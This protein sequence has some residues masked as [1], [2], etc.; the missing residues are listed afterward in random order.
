[1]WITLLLLTGDIQYIR[2][3]GAALVLLVVMLGIIDVLSTE[4]LQG[5]SLEHDQDVEHNCASRSRRG[6]SGRAGR[7]QLHNLRFSKTETVLLT[8]L[9]QDL[10]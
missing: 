6:D 4:T 8:E 7:G 3:A 10:F 1:M 9:K 2:C 5:L